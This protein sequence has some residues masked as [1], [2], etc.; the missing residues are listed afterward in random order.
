MKTRMLLIAALAG[1]TLSANAALAQDSTPGAKDMIEGEVT[2]VDMGQGKITIRGSDGTVHEFQ[3]SRETLES[4]K[5]GD[6]IKA[7]RR[8]AEPQK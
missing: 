8:A 1:L 3:A 5:V 4:Y 2:K 7:K 6:T